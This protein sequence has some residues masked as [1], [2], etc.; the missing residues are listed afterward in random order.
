MDLDTGYKYVNGLYNKDIY[1]LSS[2][3]PE[4]LRLGMKNACW[5]RWWHWL[6][7]I[8]SQEQQRDVYRGSKEIGQ[9]FQII[10]ENNSGITVN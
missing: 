10:S 7:S 2:F 4:Y 1:C 8:N 3:F 9:K 6:A 5:L